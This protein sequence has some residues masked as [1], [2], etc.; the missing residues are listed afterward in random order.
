ML[1]VTNNY[2]KNITNLRGSAKLDTKFFV[3][4]IMKKNVKCHQIK[5]PY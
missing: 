5:K 2:I 1:S 4:Y 3:Y